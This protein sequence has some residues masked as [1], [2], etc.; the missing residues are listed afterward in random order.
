M[1]KP[2]P[3]LFA[4]GDVHGHWQELYGLMTRLINN[5]SLR[6]ERDTVVF[7][8]D[9]VDGGPDTR[10][11]V[12]WCMEMSTRYPHWV[13]LK[14]NHCDLML[15]A[16]RYNERIY[17]S[18]DLWWMQGGRETARSYMPQDASPYDRAIM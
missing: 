8:G 14:G 7:L 11:V 1:P 16:L 3:K 17:G 12:E 2:T 4:I 15:D 9:L 13:F 6:P 18:Y 10:R 5:A